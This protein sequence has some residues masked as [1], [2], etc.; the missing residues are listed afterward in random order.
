MNH[1]QIKAPS[2]ADR[3]RHTWDELFSVLDFVPV[4]V[5]L[6]SWLLKNP[7][8]RGMCYLCPKKREK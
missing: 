7:R 8:D 2:E 3:S 4:L 5:K 1:Y 6:H